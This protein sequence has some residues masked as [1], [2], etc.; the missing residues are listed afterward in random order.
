MSVDYSLYKSYIEFFK[1][2]K[3]SGDN[4]DSVITH[5]FFISETVNGKLYDESIIKNIPQQYND[6]YNVLPTPL[7][8]LYT[9][10]GANKEYTNHFTFLT[11]KEINEKNTNYE[12]FYDI[13]IRYLGMG[14]TLVLSC[15]RNK[16]NYFIRRDGGSSYYDREY[17]Y[18]RYKNYNPG[19]EEKEDFFVELHKL[20]NFSELIKYLEDNFQSSSS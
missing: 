10:I 19:I 1:K 4:P 13:A 15:Y 20:M 11:L 18:N 7:K 12:Q 9:T 8:I 5:P 6:L 3:I 14:H 2:G 17:N 16:D